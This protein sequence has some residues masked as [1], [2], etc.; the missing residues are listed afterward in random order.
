[1][2]KNVTDASGIAEVRRR[3]YVGMTRARDGLVLTYHGALPDAM[4]PIQKFVKSE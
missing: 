1:M 4:K 2:F 3:L